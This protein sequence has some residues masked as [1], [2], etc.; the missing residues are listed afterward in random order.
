MNTA[1]DYQIETECHSTT[2]RKSCETC[3]LHQACQYYAEIFDYHG[4]YKYTISNKRLI[5]FTA[6]ICKHYENAVVLV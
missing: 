5:N 6:E 2:E 1:I 3:R 4:S